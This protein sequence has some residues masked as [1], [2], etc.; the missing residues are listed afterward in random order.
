MGTTWAKIHFLND[1]KR[2]DYHKKKKKKKIQTFSIAF[3]LFFVSWSANVTE[4]FQPL[5]KWSDE[6]YSKK[7]EQKKTYTQKSCYIPLCTILPHQHPTHVHGDIGPVTW[8]TNRRADVVQW[9]GCSALSVWR[10]HG[11][12]HVLQAQGGSRFPRKLART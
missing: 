5:S 12:L 9:D 2:Y 6:E 7:E 4:D 1:N 11:G 8:E 10:H 3:F